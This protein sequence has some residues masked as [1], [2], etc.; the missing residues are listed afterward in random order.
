MEGILEVNSAGEELDG[1]VFSRA[2][3]SLGRWDLSI[4]YGISDVCELP[5]GPISS[6]KTKAVLWK[7]KGKGKAWKDKKRGL[8][9]AAIHI[10]CPQEERLWREEGLG[11]C[12]Q[13]GGM[14]SV[15]PD[16]HLCIPGGSPQWAL[17]PL[18]RVL[19][20][21][22]PTTTQN[23]DFVSIPQNPLWVAVGYHWCRIECEFLTLTA[24]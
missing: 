22:L 18:P 16:P 4:F 7:E 17:C 20:V 19:P 15:P 3:L 14:I 21:I 8:Q 10:G 9:G 11:C 5:W 23:S 12:W 24:P 1:G 13:E 6:L 2:F